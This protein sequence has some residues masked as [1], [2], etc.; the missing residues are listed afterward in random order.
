MAGRIRIPPYKP[1]DVHTPAIPGG[2]YIDVDASVG[3]FA[4][5]PLMQFGLQA[6]EGVAGIAQVVS[7]HVARDD[8]AV[9]K[10]ADMRLGEAEQALTDGRFAPGAR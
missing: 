9:V 1:L 6:A 7:A 8:E 10:A 5:S 3:N 2:G 4:P